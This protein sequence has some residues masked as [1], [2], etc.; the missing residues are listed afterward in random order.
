MVDWLYGIP[1]TPTLGSGV[2]HNRRD[3]YS[4]AHHQWRDRPPARKDQPL[5]L[6][7]SFPAGFRAASCN[8]GSRHASPVAI[9]RRQRKAVLTFFRKYIFEIALGISMVSL[10]TSI[11][12]TGYLM[13]NRPNRPDYSSGFVYPFQV[14]GPKVF[15]TAPD[16]NCLSLSSIVFILCFGCI[17]YTLG[18]RT[19]PNDVTLDETG[20]FHVGKRNRPSDRRMIF[21]S[22]IVAASCF[23]LFG[24]LVADFLAVH[25]MVFAFPG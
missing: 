16:A 8:R 6:R 5:A 20:S 3:C 24:R 15:I 9:S 4:A 21:A 25:G 17:A 10:I 11:W 13:L 23:L 12:E 2:K 22:L 14:R 19:H 7:N 1:G 18:P